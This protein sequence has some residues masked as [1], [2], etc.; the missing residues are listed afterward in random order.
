MRVGVAGAF[1]RLCAL[2]C[3]FLGACLALRCEAI[4][5]AHREG[6]VLYHSD[7]TTLKHPLLSWQLD[8]Q[9]D[10]QEDSRQQQQ[11]KEQPLRY[12]VDRMHQQGLSLPLS[13]PML[14]VADATGVAVVMVPDALA[15]AWLPLLM[16]AE[17]ASE[18]YTLSGLSFE[19]ATG[20]VELVGRLQIS[21]EPPP[22][23]ELP[24]NPA[25]LAVSSCSR[26]HAA[27]A[28]RAGI[29]AI[30]ALDSVA[31]SQ[32][33]ARSS[34]EQLFDVLS[35]KHSPGDPRPRATVLVTVEHIGTAPSA[36]WS[37]DP[38]PLQLLLCV[39]DES[40]AA[41]G[42]QNVLVVVSDRFQMLSCAACLEVGDCLLIRDALVCPASYCRY[43]H[44]TPFTAGL[45]QVS[46]R[47][48]PDAHSTFFAFAHYSQP[49][50]FPLRCWT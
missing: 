15:D 49:G 30:S 25:I 42:M 48:V 14:L 28:V 21:I 2:V 11:R 19:K 32:L 37:E 24:V 46:P 9:E 35:K 8:V 31:M 20:G 23:Y 27:G 47:R 17:F 41:A 3:A 22:G 33:L 26:F 29:A 13:P 36:S 5:K 50:T 10:Q 43:L 45:L 39:R 18:R 4:L 12:L 1:A 34:R 7:S 40:L 44:C 6:D 16:M 38:H